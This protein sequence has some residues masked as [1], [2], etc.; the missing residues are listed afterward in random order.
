M[1]RSRSRSIGEETLERQNG[2]QLRRLCAARAG[3]HPHPGESGRDA[4]H[5]AR[6]QH[7]LGR[8]DR[9]HLCRRHAVRRQR[10]PS[11]AA[12]LAG[13]FDTFDVARIE[14]LRGPQGTL[15]GTNALGGVLKFVTAVPSTDRFEARAQV[16]V[17]DTRYGEIG[18]FGNA[19]VNVPLGDTIAFRASGFY[20]DNRRLCRR[21]GAR[22]RRNVNASDELWRPRVAAVHADRRA[23]DPA[24][25]AGS[26]TS[27]P[28]RRRASSPI[29]RRCE[30]VDPVTGAP[31]GEAN[32]TRYERI[33]EFNRLDYRL[34]AGTID[35]DFG[36]A[37]ADLGHQLQRA[38]SAT[39]SA[40]SARPSVPRPR[41]PA[42]RARP[43]PARSAWRSTNDVEVEKF[44]QE[45]RLQS[46]DGDRFEWLVGGYYT[47]EE[48]A[49]L[50]EILP[51]TLATQELIPPATTVP[52]FFGPPFGGNVLTNFV[53][54]SIIADYEEIAAFASATFKFNDRFDI[55][56][57]GRYSHNEQIALTA[58]HPARR[59]RA[60]DRR[61]RRKACSPGRSRRASSSATT[62]RSMRASPRATGRAARTSSRRAP[63]RTSRPS[64]ARTSLISYELGFRAADRGPHC[65]RSTARSIISTGTT[66]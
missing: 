50:Q 20:R 57:G 27:T 63:G 24:V 31:V 44:T 12:I 38:D 41:E 2:A 11:N 62:P 5:P 6:R 16:G 29:R 64:S 7:R 21:P 15:Y 56:A 37:N 26:R 54:S 39:S 14:V 22:R 10:Q 19:M 40:T 46:P 23:F 61:I 17:E 58:D 36:F 34:Y 13:D 8:L 55:T 51:F 45:V 60:A 33:A 30:P 65:S 53:T 48:T 59:G 47:D 18:Y 66:S 3:P 52:L 35:Y 49:L 1:S 32:R 9:R 4:A 28:T 42:V 43:R 25:R